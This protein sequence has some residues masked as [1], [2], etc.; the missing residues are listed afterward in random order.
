MLLRLLSAAA[1][2]LTD[3]TLPA[4]KNL[5]IGLFVRLYK[6]NMHEAIHSSPKEYV[7]FNAFFARPLRAGARPLAPAPFVAPVDGRLLDATQLRAGQI[8]TIKGQTYD[9]HSLLLDNT[10]KGRRQAIAT[11]TAGFRPAIFNAGMYALFYL[12]PKD[13]HR[14][15]CPCD[16]T[17]TRLIF[18]PG[19]LRPVNA[20]AARRIPLLYAQNQRAVF[21]FDTPY[22]KMAIV[23]VAALFVSSIETRW[24]GRRH[25][26]AVASAQELNIPLRKGDELGR[27]LMGSSVILLTEYARFALVPRIGAQT[28]VGQ[29][30][31]VPET[32][33]VGHK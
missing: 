32:E 6:P 17:L 23:M 24:G 30:L 20:F 15:H 13:Y 19:R 25:A 3:C 22:G 9:L 4:I 29:P 27:F 31:F 26:L 7:S 14:V 18:I 33:V 11:D 8:P 1:R 2:V 21:W 28:Q 16:A 12:S 5:L 10:P